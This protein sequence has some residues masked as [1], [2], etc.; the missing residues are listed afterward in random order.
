MTS[1][2]DK[3]ACKQVV[4]G[5]N[6]FSYQRLPI[7]RGPW[8]QFRQNV[9][10]RPKIQSEEK[11]AI[12][13]AQ[14]PARQRRVLPRITTIGNQPFAGTGGGGS[15]GARQRGRVKL[16]GGIRKDSSTLLH[17][18]PQYGS[19]VVELW[20]AAADFPERYRRHGRCD[21]TR[22]ARPLASP[23]AAVAKASP[24]AKAMA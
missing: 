20:F 10:A 19:S 7:R 12:A 14:S 16:E 8:S 6:Q 24:A 21:Q 5:P 4:E 13:R 1:R 23:R 18:I 9:L 2:R 15:L 17:C 11:F 22:T 3:S